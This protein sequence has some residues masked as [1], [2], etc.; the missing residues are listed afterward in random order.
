MAKRK[1]EALNDD[2]ISGYLVEVSPIKTSQQNNKY[3]DG[4]INSNRKT[5]QHFD[6]SKHSQ[7]R[8]AGTQKSPVKL[9]RISQVPNFSCKEQPKETSEQ[10]TLEKMQNLPEKSKSSC[11][12]TTVVSV[13][14]HCRRD[15]SSSSLDTC[16]N[17][18]SVLSSKSDMYGKKY[19][20]VPIHQRLFQKMAQRGFSTDFK[21]Q[22]RNITSRDQSLPTRL[23][24][25]LQNEIKT[26]RPLLKFELNVDYNNTIPPSD[27][28]MSHINDTS[29]LED[30]N[31]NVHAMQT[32]ENWILRHMDKGM[33]ATHEYV[34]V[35]TQVGH[36]KDVRDVGIYTEGIKDDD[37]K[38]KFYTGFP[39]IK[40]F[41]LFFL[42]L[43]K[44]GAKELNYWEGVKRS[45]GDKLLWEGNV[46]DRNI[47]EHDG[48]IHKLPPGDV[49]MS[50][51]GF[52]I[53]DLLSPDIGLNVPP[54]VSTKHQMSS[55]EFFKTANIA[56]ARIVIEMKVK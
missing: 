30:L 38:V 18:T 28:E 10:C 51:K 27:T 41:W 44:H 46:S 42:T 7:F 31:E 13:S 5:F 45:M 50:D 2:E 37:S 26:T 4:T 48:L 17:S 54:R 20:C 22:K 39:T 29:V 23:Q 47:V 53:E 16:T 34:Y 55:S 15:A 33:N 24:P 9:Q 43:T 11:Y 36:A 25:K 56:A 21:C 49:K 3:F 32:F 40:V 12:I 52:T 8:S 35:E 14:V 1:A 19:C 6:V